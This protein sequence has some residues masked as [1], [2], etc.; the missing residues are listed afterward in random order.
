MTPPQRLTHCCIPR[1]KQ[2]D[3]IAAELTAGEL[4]SGYGVYEADS[5]TCS[6]PEETAIPSGG[7]ITI[8]AERSVFAESQPTISEATWNRHIMRERERASMVNGAS[9]VA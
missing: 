4:N 3:Q 9:R 8:R 2:T 7:P 6:I 5:I 1:Q